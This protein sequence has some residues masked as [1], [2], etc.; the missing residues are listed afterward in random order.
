L[1]HCR[2]RGEEA[3]GPVLASVPGDFVVYLGAD[4]VPD[5]L[6]RGLAS[7]LL[8]WIDWVEVEVLGFPELLERM[9][10]LRGAVMTASAGPCQRPS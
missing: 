8:T 2:G 6:D 3:N 10:R 7:L 4:D 9:R 1:D 5:R